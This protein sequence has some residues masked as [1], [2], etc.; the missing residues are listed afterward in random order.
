LAAAQNRT[1]TLQAIAKLKGGERETR[2]REGAP[3]EGNLI[4]Y[5]S[6]TARIR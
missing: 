6:T 2:L 1:E 5:S 4:W 3:K